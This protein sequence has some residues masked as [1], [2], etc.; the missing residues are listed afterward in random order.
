MA[1]YKPKQ[2]SKVQ[3]GL[4]I[5]RQMY[6]EA[7]NSQNVYQNVVLDYILLHYLIKRENTTG[8]LC[9]KTFGVSVQ[10][11]KAFYVFIFMSYTKI[12]CLL[13]RASS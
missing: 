6:L 5:T 13:Y 10:K 3:H 1:V 7:I 9:L 12:L 8:M 4:S 2:L 11:E